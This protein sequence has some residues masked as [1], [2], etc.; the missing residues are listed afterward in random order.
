MPLKKKQSWVVSPYHNVCNGF[1][2]VM[3]F[4]G[5]TRSVS[6]GGFVIKMVTCLRRETDK[7][8]HCCVVN[9]GET[10]A[11]WWLCAVLFTLSGS[12]RSYGACG[13]HHRMYSVFSNVTCPYFNFAS[14]S[15]SFVEKKKSTT[16]YIFNKLITI[17][18][19]V[20]QRG[21]LKIGLG[22]LRSENNNIKHNKYI[23]K[24]RQ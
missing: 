8:V 14:L 20:F 13:A 5:D 11:K 21:L 17:L 24:N 4:Y 7:I 22:H 3:S 10:T 2:W 18:I 6:S 19:F 12:L 15:I 16:I 1:Y 9:G 23:L